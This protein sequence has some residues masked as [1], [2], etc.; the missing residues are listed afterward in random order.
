MIECYILDIKYAYILKWHIWTEN[1]TSHA[2]GIITRYQGV[3][4]GREIAK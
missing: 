3:A 4:G 1:S 2:E